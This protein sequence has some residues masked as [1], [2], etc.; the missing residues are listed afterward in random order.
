MDGFKVRVS[1]TIELRA[2]DASNLRIDAEELAEGVLSSDL[3]I[4]SAS[5]ED[6]TV[7]IEVDVSQSDVEVA[8]SDIDEFDPTDFLDSATEHWDANTKNAEFEVEE[9]P[10]GFDIVEGVTDRETA[11]AVYVAL[12]AAGYDVI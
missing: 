12:A 6:A 1:G 7:T 9:S 2:L 10:A 5:V 3:T 8:I 4:E 11:I